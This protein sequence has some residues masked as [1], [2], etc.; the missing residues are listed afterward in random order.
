ML[1]VFKDYVHVVQEL[2]RGCFQGSVRLYRC[3]ALFL[4]KGLFVVIL[5]FVCGLWNGCISIVSGLHQ[6]R[7]KHCTK[8]YSR[9]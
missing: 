9:R 6:E 3:W 8:L 1:K 4:K 2:Y 5:T 7:R